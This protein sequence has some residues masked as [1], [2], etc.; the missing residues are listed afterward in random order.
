MPRRLPKPCRHPGCPELTHERYC[1][2]HATQHQSDITSKRQVN[3]QL[4]QEHRFYNSPT[5][6]ALRAQH[7]SREPLCRSCGAKGRDVDHKVPINQ[8]GKRTDPNN[9]QTLCQSCHNRKRQRESL[10]RF[11]QRANANPEKP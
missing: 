9:L 3:P 7:L 1:P 2:P 8:G 11:P 6:R 5:W 10:S 4:A